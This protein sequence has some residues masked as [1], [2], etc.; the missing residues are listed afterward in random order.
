MCRSAQGRNNR[1]LTPMNLH[2]VVYAYKSQF[3]CVEPSL[4]F[5]VHLVS[6]ETGWG[7]PQTSL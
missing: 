5:A 3:L 7:R 6:L 1:V 2:V 4:T